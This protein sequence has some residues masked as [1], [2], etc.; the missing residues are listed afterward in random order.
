MLYEN[1]KANSAPMLCKA[2]NRNNQTRSQKYKKLNE[3]KTDTP[4]VKA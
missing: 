4:D 1:L 3:N 2:K